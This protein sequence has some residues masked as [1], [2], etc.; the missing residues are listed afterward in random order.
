M[1]VHLNKK[2]FRKCYTYHN[3]VGRI[4][5]TGSWFALRLRKPKWSAI[6]N[7]RSPRNREGKLLFNPFPVG[8]RCTE[9]FPSGYLQARFI[10][11]MWN[12]TRDPTV[13]ASV[14]RR[15]VLFGGTANA[16]RLDWKIVVLCPR[17]SFSRILPQ[18]LF[19][20]YTF[21]QEVLRNDSIAEF[22]CVIARR[23]FTT[24]ISGVFLTHRNYGLFSRLYMRENEILWAAGVYIH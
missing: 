22:S 18:P 7:A 16:P 1:F 23:D 13:I 10:P 4:E 21:R 20:T 6:P 2:C 24:P 11:S 12:G 8:T 14:V 17:K 5:I 9:S 15:F 19:S 3:S